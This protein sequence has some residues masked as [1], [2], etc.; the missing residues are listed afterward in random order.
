MASAVN[1]GG[2][3]QFVSAS[4]ASS[5]PTSDFTRLCRQSLAEM[6][7]TTPCFS[8]TVTD[9]LKILH[10]HHRPKSPIVPF[11]FLNLNFNKIITFNRLLLVLNVKRNKELLPPQVESLPP[12]ALPLALRSGLCVRAE[13]RYRLARPPSSKR[14]AS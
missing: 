7:L 8:Y 14:L 13:T 4:E 3:S 2:S 12:S 5:G 6:T 1:V 11:L 10:H 9:Y